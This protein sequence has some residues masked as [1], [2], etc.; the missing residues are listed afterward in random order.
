MGQFYEFDLHDA[1]CLTIV[2][3]PIWGLMG[4]CTYLENHHVPYRLSQWEF[5]EPG[6]PGGYYFRG[7]RGYDAFYLVSDKDPVDLLDIAEETFFVPLKEIGEEYCP[8][9]AGHADC[10][11]ADLWR[12]DVVELEDCIAAGG[13]IREWLEGRWEY[14]HSMLYGEEA[15]EAFKEMLRHKVEEAE[16]VDEA[17]VEEAP[18]AAPHAP[19]LTASEYDGIPVLVDEYGYIYDEYGNV[20]GVDE[21]V[22]GEDSESVV[23]EN[24]CGKDSEPVVDMET[25]CGD[26]GT[27]VNAGSES[28]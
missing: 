10:T 5:C 26:A 7:Q 15:V 6:A 16:E 28:Q 18:L 20:L 11:T 27:G 4:V 8:V 24:L 14:S 19:S 9:D 21:T 25:G 17:A 23:E 13:P 3:L 2:A 22:C 1:G 12:E